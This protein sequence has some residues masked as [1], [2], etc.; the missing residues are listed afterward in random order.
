MLPTTFGFD[1]F[2]FL[3]VL[4]LGAWRT[5]DLS[6]EGKD[7]TNINFIKIAS[8]VKFIDTI[9]YYQ[10]RLFVLASPMTDEERYCVKKECKKFI[11]NDSK[12][13]FKFQKCSDVNKEWILNYVSSCKRIIS[14]V[15]ITRYDSL[16]IAPE[17][18][19]FF[20]PH[21]FDSSLKNKIASRRL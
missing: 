18:G 8:Q 11:K 17:D 6:V 12:L 4:R 1:F 16:D 20:L 19:V 7:L 5:T 21:D 3:K 9:K 10:Q 13:N 15:M 2:F 14:Y